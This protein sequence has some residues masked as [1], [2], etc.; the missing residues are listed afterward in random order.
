[1]PAEPIAVCSCAERVEVVADVDLV[2]RQ[3]H[4]RGA[5][6]DD[7]LQLAP[8]GDAAAEVVDE[9]AQRRAGLD[10]VVAAVHDVAGERD[11]ARAARVRD[12][13]LRVL[14]AAHRDDRRRRS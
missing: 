9:L 1:M 4:G 2:L 10:L 12:A 11:D 8:V 7:R 5:A 3:D 13:E 14:G 6:R